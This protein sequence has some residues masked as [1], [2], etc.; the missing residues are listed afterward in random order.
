LDC[1]GGVFNC[2]FLTIGG[3]SAESEIS[4]G[5]E[6]RGQLLHLFKRL[7]EIGGHLGTR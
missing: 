5:L 2:S 4:V 6:V 1:F 7:I 3:F